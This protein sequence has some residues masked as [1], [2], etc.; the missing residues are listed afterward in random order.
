MYRALTNIRR[1]ACALA[2]LLV[3]SQLLSI[4]HSEAI[5]GVAAGEELKKIL[6]VEKAGGPEAVTGDTVKMVLEAGTKSKFITEEGE[7]GCAKSEAAGQIIFNPVIGV[8]NQAEI[9]F[10]ALTFAECSTT[11]S[12]YTTKGVQ[13]E[14]LPLIAK[15]VGTTGFEIQGERFRSKVTLE[16]TG[17]SGGLERV[18][19][20]GAVLKPAYRNNNEGELEINQAI[21]ETE[22]NKKNCNPFQFPAAPTWKASY[23]PL[24]DETGV[25]AG[26]QIFLN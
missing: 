9:K 16:F 26:K 15:T 4:G 3:S 14:E 19:S 22:V 13:I 18:C 25:R 23:R 20:Y 8:G 6:T 17:E 11:I 5:T 12:G 24:R 1:S 2:S 10:E 21:K 7:I